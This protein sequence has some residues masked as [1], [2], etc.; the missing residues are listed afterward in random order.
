MT[1][2]TE[3][4]LVGLVKHIVKQLVQEYSVWD[5]SQSSPST[6][7][8]QPD[9][10]DNQVTDPNNMSATPMSTSD[11]MKLDKIKK[12]QTQ[13]DIKQKQLELDTVKKKLDFTKKDQDQMKRSQIPTLQKSIQQLKSQH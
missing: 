9:N 3:E 7:T 1:T 2:I 4:K 12:T 8:T 10:T 13:N 5:N 11:K 6:G